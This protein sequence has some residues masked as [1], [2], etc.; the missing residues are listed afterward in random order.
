VEAGSRE[1]NASN[2]KRP[3]RLLVAIDAIAPV[4]HLRCTSY[5]KRDI[6][7]ETMMQNETSQMP[8]DAPRDYPARLAAP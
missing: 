4:P 2:R 6:P 7:R 8:G 5:N 3:P 1:E